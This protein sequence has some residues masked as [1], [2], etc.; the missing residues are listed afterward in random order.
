MSWHALSFDVEHWYDATLV[1]RGGS[2]PGQAG[3]AEREVDAVLAMLAERDARA[4]FFVLGALAAELPQVVRGV[5]AAGHEVACHGWGHEL[6]GALG[7]GRFGAAARRARALLQDLSGQ[8]VRGYRAAT[9]SI[10]PATAWASEELCRAGFAYDS[11]VFPLRT[12]LYGMASAPRVPYRIATAGG[13]IVELPPAVGA[14]GPLP[15]P[16]AGGI[17]WRVLPLWVVRAGLARMAAPA[18]LYAHPWEV[19][20]AGWRL[21]PHTPLGVRLSMHFGSA[22]LARV[23]A[24]LVA[25][26]EVRPLAVLEAHCRARPGARYRWVGGRLVAEATAAGPD[27]PL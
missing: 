23:L 21:P 13:E 27:A 24:A 9:W 18:V 17:Y 12:P 3:D 1:G 26:V 6:A 16:L 22:H 20:P 7:P 15:V 10:G 14:F 19:A 2:R 4:T 25:S 8:E 5:A 11:S